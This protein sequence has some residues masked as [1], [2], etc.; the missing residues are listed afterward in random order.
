LREKTAKRTGNRGYVKGNV[1][2][3]GRDEEDIKLVKE[4]SR[5]RGNA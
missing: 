2:E 4:K 5:E 1:V 3:G